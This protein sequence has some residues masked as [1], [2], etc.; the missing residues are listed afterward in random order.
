MRLTINKEE[1][2][3]GLLTAGHAVGPKSSNPVLMTLKLDMTSRGLE[4]TGSDGDV[5]I[6]T[7]VPVALGETEIIRNIGEGGALVEAKKL[8]ELI[9]RLDTAEV[10]LEVI[11]GTTARISGGNNVTNLPSIEVDQYPDIELEEAREA[12]EMPVKTLIDVVD[13]TSFAAPIKNSRP[14]L[15]GINLRA[16]GG[17]LTATA[18]DSARLSSKMVAIPENVEFTANVPAKTLSGLVRMF[19]GYESVRIS[20]FPEKILFAYG[21]TLVSC[22]VLSG[23]YPVSS[24]VIPNTF[25]YFLEVNALELLSAIERISVLNID[26]TPLV[27]LTMTRERVEVSAKNGQ[28]GYAAECLETF[29]YT[30]ERLE[31]NFNSSYVADAIK[32]V[33]SQDVLISFVA[34]MKPFVIKSPKDDSVIEL[35]T[36][37]RT[38]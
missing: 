3:K 9:K 32:A 11:D 6:K 17:M 35:V 22:S 31:I 28:D 34:E 27:K 7:L 2:L 26:R 29:Q 24:R 1:F 16:S 38:R 37:M 8:I 12:F 14:V 18:T 13:Q 21:N 19:E 10:T 5:T 33:R 20:R 4:I 15:T 23:D 36:P 30:G 25:N